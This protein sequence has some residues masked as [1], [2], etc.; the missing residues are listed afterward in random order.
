MSTPKR[1]RVP[2]AQRDPYTPASP[3]VGTLQ[4]KRDQLEHRLDDGYQKIGEA[5]LKGQDVAAWE[6][7]WFS[8]LADYEA[9]CDELLEKGS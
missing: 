6:A 2:P 3:T 7:F 1:R 9:V 5:E 4:A 8:L